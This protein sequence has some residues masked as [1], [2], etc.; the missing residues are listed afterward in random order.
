M[1]GKRVADVSAENDR[2][3]Y[4]AKKR[5]AMASLNLTCGITVL[6]VRFH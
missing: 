3:K 4:E 2:E 1:A 5:L 6:I